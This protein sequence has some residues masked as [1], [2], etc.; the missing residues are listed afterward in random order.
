MSSGQTSLRRRGR[1]KACLPGK[2]PTSHPSAALQ[3]HKPLLAASLPSSSR[4]LHPSRFSLCPPNP[5]TTHPATSPCLPLRFVACASQGSPHPVHD[6]CTVQHHSWH[7]MLSWCMIT[8]LHSG[9][10]FAAAVNSEGTCSFCSCFSLL[11]HRNHDCMAAVP[12]QAIAECRRRHEWRI[13][14]YSCMKSWR[15]NELQ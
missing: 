3:L 5:P 1:R 2:R 15:P 12:E 8:V 11:P 14:Q 7:S 9:C 10:R 13:K 4:L 6:L